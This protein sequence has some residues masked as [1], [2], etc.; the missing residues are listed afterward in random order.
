VKRTVSCSLLFFSLLG[1]L[2][3]ARGDAGTDI[4]DLEG[5]WLP[6]SGEIAGKKYPDEVLKTIKLV[7]KDDKYTVTVGDLIDEG[8]CK[9]DPSKSPK[10]LDIK[11]TKGP[12][13]GKTILAIYDLKKDTLRVCYDLSGKERPAEFATKADT[14]LFLL[15]YK[16]AKL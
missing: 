8:T 12:N 3:L 16:R 4:K 5:T 9:I 13:E 10:A 11:G 1:A 7:L 15:T 14:S 2:A 6:L